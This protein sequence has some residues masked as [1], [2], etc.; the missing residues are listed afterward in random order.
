MKLKVC[1]AGASGR[2]GKPLCPAVSEADDLSL[3]GAVSRTL[4]GR[5]LSDVFGDSN[6]DLS[7]RGSLPA[8][9]KVRGRA[10]LIRG[11]DKIME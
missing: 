2:V 11:L 7:V 1:V 4:Q 5:N 6:L 9:R 3:V 8:I 10:G